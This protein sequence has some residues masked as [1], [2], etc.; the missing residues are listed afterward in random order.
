M[1]RFIKH[2]LLNKK[3]LNFCLLV[4]VA[5]LAAV[6]S[7]HTMFK[8]GSLNKLLQKDFTDY[9]EENG[10]YPAVISR[11]GSCSVDS[12]SDVASVYERLESYEAKWTEYIDTDVVNSE[13]IIRVTGGS[14]STSLGGKNKYF[15]IGTIR[16]MDEHITIVKGEGLAESNTEDG[17]YPC[18]VSESVMDTYGLV[19]GE[20]LTL[21]YCLD[22][23]GNP[24]NFKIT[25]IFSEKDT[26]DNFWYMQTGEKIFFTDEDSMNDFISRYQAENILYDEYLLL[27]YTQINCSNVRDYKYYLE[28][29]EKADDRLECSF[30]DILTQYTQDAKSVNMILWVIELPVCVLLLV[31]IYMVSSQILSLE[32]QEIAMLKSRGVTRRKILGLYALQSIIIS[33]LGGVLGIVMG[34]GLCR[35]A[36]HT[37]SFLSFVKKDVSIYTFTVGMPAFALIACV[38]AVVFMT[39]PVLSLSK[40]NIVQLK[41][42]KTSGTGR[43]KPFWEKYFLDV[44]FLLVSIYLLYNYYKQSDDI[45]M[46]AISGGK[47][48]PVIFLDSSLFILAAGIFVL[49]LVKYLVRLVYFLGRKRWK[50]AVYT[51]FL[52]IMRSVKKQGFISVFLVMTIAM[53]IFNANMART[54]NRNNEERIEYNEGCDVRFQEKWSLK[55]YML[56]AGETVQLYTEPDYERYKGLLDENICESIT[57]VLTDDETDVSLKSKT[58]SGCMLMGINTKEFG[59]TA[60]LKSGLNDEHWFNALNALAASPDGVIISRNLAEKLEADVG[61]TITYSRYNSIFD[62][63]DGKKTVSGVKVCAIVDAWPGYDRYKYKQN[64]DGTFAEDENYLIVANYAT[65]VSRFGQTPY[66]IWMKLSEDA[67]VNAVESYISDSGIKQQDISSISEDMDE[68]QDLALIQITNG[69]F[70]ISFLISLVLCL[71]GFLIYWIMSVKSR[72]LSFGIYRAMGMS[73]GEIGRMLINEQLFT[74]IPA[75]AAG[76]GVGLISTHL[77]TS[78]ISLVYLPE[79]HNISLEIFISM[80]DMLKVA[81]VVLLM[82]LVCIVIMRKIVGSMNITQALKMGED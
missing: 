80:S 26:G 14:S 70:T 75:C 8:D 32:E 42:K 69:M 59:E 19:V 5:L 77:F 27:D 2:K 71:A 76:I 78:L 62:D 7:C 73:R 34:Y 48:D 20:V 65:V 41:N 17:I 72:Q 53:G 55:V 46:N 63:T 9:A 50:P 43:E 38:I 25:G 58:V 6:F 37:N 15:D 18:I 1:L 29:F 13:Q 67:D 11:S 74:S 54:I 51:S 35:L 30:L 68:M 49:R 64:D 23:S 31:F 33:L 79:K 10:K 60:V 45:A 24:A 16:D 47:L 52:Q 21:D 3:W 44:I 36:A 39:L 12:C 22:S 40:T 57:R 81:L 66:G 56:G 4:G 28:Q 82:I 61:T